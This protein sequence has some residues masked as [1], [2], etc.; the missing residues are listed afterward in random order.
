MLQSFVITLR[1]GLEAFLIV[2]IS[3][4]YLKKTG[5]LELTRAVH[6]GV[7]ASI[8][9]SIA[10]GIALARV[11]NQAL[12]EGML[13]LLAAVL[14]ATLTVHMWRVARR[15][16]SDIHASLER[17]AQR[18]Q[19][20]AMLG[21]FLFTLFMITR[22]GMETALLMNALLQM[23]VK[24]P[25]LIAGA[26]LGV[27][28]AA[29]VALA[30]SRWGHHVNLG[31]FLQVTAVFLFVFLV[32]LLIYGFHE[33]SEAGVLPASETLHWATEPYG[34]DGRY[35]KYLSYLL[36]LLPAGWLAMSI[37]AGRKRAEVPASSP[38]A[39]G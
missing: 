36:V 27:A 24:S 31:L 16:K 17:S 3:L 34:P 6:W 20:M 9:L 7:V 13:A 28:L 12:W 19:G 15:I 5:R 39:D 23:K 10:G 35:G 25:A 4:A 38:R 21:V 30:W 29:L 22:E 2:A 37:F 18:T 1:E 14:V 32:Q 11:A 33:L 26:V 8:G